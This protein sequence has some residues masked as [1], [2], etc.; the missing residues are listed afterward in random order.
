MIVNYTNQG[1]EVITQRAHGLLAAQLAMHWNK[2]ERPT[3]W[4]ETLLAIAEHDDARTELESDQLL[5]EQGGPLNFDMQLFDPEHCRLMANISLSKSRYIALLTSMHMVFL[6][7]KEADSN[8]LVKPFLKEQARLQKQWRTNL[9][10]DEQE[11]S[12][13]YRLLEW[14]D[15][16]SLLLCRNEVQ[17]EKRNI[18]ISQGPSNTTYHLRQKSNGQ[19]TVTPWPFEEDEFQV[20]LEKRIIPQL[21]FKDNEDFKKH[22]VSAPVEEIIWAFKM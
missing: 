18:E 16:C 17:P 7:E 2:K 6:F 12:R 13:I 3:R 19:L 15:A 5:T 8:P 1:W 9:A 4:T 11:T 20:R 14:C 10:I 22:F 21:H